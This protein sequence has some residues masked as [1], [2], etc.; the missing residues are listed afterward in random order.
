MDAGVFPKVVV[1]F[2]A[3]EH[4]DVNNG[5][6]TQDEVDLIVDKHFIE[7]ISEDRAEPVGGIGGED[8]VYE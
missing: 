2:E 6:D 4:D 7:D 5:E 1:E 8:V 3:G